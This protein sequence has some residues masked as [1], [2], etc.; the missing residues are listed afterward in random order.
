VAAETIRVNVWLKTADP[1]VGDEWFDDFEIT[2]GEPIIYKGRRWI[3]SHTYRAR[4]QAQ[5][6][7]RLAH[8]R[9]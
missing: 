1:E 3:F 8:L 4:R 7:D 5:H 9:R 2:P 6:R